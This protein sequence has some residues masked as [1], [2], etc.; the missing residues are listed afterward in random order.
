MSV[1]P[2][3]PAQFQN[4]KWLFK[5]GFSCGLKFECSPNSLIEHVGQSLKAFY[6]PH[7]GLFIPQ[8]WTES[9]NWD[10]GN[11]KIGSL[12]DSQVTL[13]SE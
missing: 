7:G 10:G 1:A 6:I 5:K 3:Y 13:A 11:I 4:Y 2:R 12:Q 9:T 8:L